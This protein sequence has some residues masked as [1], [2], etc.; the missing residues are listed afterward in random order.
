VTKVDPLNTSS[1]K[2]EPGAGSV[3]EVAVAGH[4]FCRLAVDEVPARR[5]RP[6]PV[7][8]GTDAIHPSLLRYS[9]EQTVA[10]VCSVFSGVKELGGDPKR[11]DDWGVVAAPRYQGRA[12]F[13]HNLRR[14]AAEGVWSVSPHLI[15]H[16]A[17]HAEAGTISL[18]LKSHGPNLGV[19]GGLHAAADGFLVAASWLASGTVP[20][21]W[22]VLSGWAPELVLDPDG[23]PSSTAE[24]QALAVAVVPVNLA[25]EQPRFRVLTGRA[26]PQEIV[27]LELE[28]LAA[29]LEIPGTL[30]PRILVT[31]P[32]GSLCVEL[33]PTPRPTAPSAFE[34]IRAHSPATS[35]TPPPHVLRSLSADRSK[36]VLDTTGDGA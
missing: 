18:A 23:G 15:P 21:V 36:A 29:S 20:G 4:A 19:G 12:G 17:L 33:I 16:F 5:R 11:F 27:C 2:A 26:R 14:F 35:R 22:L 10:A 1:S 31:D 9:D 34:D 25:P 6:G 7:R 28:S 30:A 3:L 32:S 24:C 8:E 13:A